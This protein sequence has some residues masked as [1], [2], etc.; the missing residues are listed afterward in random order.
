[1]QFTSYLSVPLV[2]LTW[3]CKWIFLR[4]THGELVSSTANI[5]PLDHHFLRKDQ[6]ILNYFVN[7]LYNDFCRLFPSV[8]INV[9]NILVWSSEQNSSVP[10]VFLFF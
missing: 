5:C 6:Q 10:Q 1:M 3:S 8:H 4:I 9:P 2:M 7:F